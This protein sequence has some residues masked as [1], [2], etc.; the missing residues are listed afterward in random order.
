MRTLANWLTVMFMGMYWIFRIAV[1]YM[2]ATGREFIVTP[3]NQTTEVVLLFITFICMIMVV[4][5]QKW[6]GLI[7]LATYSLYFGVD[8]YQNLIPLVNGT[9]ITA[10][11]STNLVSSVIAIIIAIVTMINLLADN[12]KRTADVKTD[13]FYGNKDTDRKLD[14]RADKNNYRI[15]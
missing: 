10:N 14:D 6:G 4:K 12:V 1:A 3:I 7:Y 8:I 11:I 13:W 2:A 15:M 5:R 9:M